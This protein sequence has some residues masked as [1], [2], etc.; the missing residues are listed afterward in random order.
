M[1]PSYDYR[2][3]AHAQGVVRPFD[4]LVR[5]DPSSR[6]LIANL[7]RC[8]LRGHE[9]PE[10]EAWRI[11][12]QNLRGLQARTHSLHAQLTPFSR[13]H[14]WGEIVARVAR[15]VG[16][17]VPPGLSPAEL[18]QLVFERLADL[19]VQRNL[20]TESDVLDALADTNV[21]FDRA[22]RHMRLGQNGPRAVW[23]ALVMAT[24]RADQSLRDGAWKIGEWLCA[25]LRWAWPAPLTIGL[26]LL[27]QRVTGVY[28]A[29]ATRG[30]SGDP[31]KNSERVC[32]ALAVILFQ[33]IVERSLDEVE[34][35]R[36]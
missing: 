12:N 1:A 21:D 4:I 24:V 15:W 32:T 2:R 16:I 25:G 29:W 34:T 17:L 13:N 20:Q 19:F 27:Q 6:R 31:H 7:L 26:R 28:C 14:T 33:D 35:L 10:P 3:H 30:F 18:E 36:S 5:M 22:L 11:I 9:G 8:D 23:S